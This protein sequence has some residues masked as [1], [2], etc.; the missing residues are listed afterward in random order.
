MF[1]FTVLKGDVL[2]DLFQNYLTM[3]HKLRTTEPVEM[4]GLP[5]LQVIL[6]FLIN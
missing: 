5:I 6:F 4:G 1:K 2:C 3:E